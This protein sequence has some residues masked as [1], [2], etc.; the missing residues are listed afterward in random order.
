MT[1]TILNRPAPEE[2]GRDTPA[3]DYVVHHR[4]ANSAQTAKT[5]KL[6]TA[7]LAPGATLEVR[8]RHSFRVITTR[9]YY[10]GPHG[11]ALQVTGVASEV[12]SFEPAP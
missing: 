5:Y 6:T 2:P 10:P 4:K 9:R 7:T 12:V 8:R 11:I 3:I 1:P